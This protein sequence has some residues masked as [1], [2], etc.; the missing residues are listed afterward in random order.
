M[1]SFPDSLVSLAVVFSVNAYISRFLLS[2]QH[3]QD[4][5]FFPNLLTAHVCYVYD[6]SSPGSQTLTSFVFRDF[7]PVQVSISAS[8]ESNVVASRLSEERS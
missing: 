2:H 6:A 7:I 3:Q 1:T 4:H 8:G 5:R